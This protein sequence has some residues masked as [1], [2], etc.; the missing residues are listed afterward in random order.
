MFGR[1]T[2]RLGIGPHSS[3]G[4]NSVVPLSRNDPGLVVSTS[5]STATRGAI[6]TCCLFHSVSFCLFFV[7]P[8][9]DYCIPYPPCK[10]ES[11]KLATTATWSACLSV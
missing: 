3:D 11:V 1:V 9:L 2:I 5:D 4:F 8:W 6:Q 7:A 10:K